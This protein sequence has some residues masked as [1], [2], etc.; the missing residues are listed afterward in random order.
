MKPDP[1][2]AAGAVMS[3]LTLALH[4]I[5]GT[6]EFPGVV[7]EYDL[8]S[9]QSSMYMILWHAVTVVLAAGT[10]AYAAAAVERRFRAAA[11]LVNVQFAGFAALFLFYG[12]AWLGSVWIL[13]QW[14]LFALMAGTTIPGLLRQHNAGTHA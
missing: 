7:L 4:V 1:F 10:L 11:L 12:V 14:V 13:P 3:G 2:L 8:G 5:G 6:P 9:K